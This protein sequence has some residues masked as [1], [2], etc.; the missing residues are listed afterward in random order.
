M[1]I[2]GDMYLMTRVIG[3]DLETRDPNLMEMGPGAVRKDGYVLGIALYYDGKNEYIPLRHDSGNADREQTIRFL[4]D[5]LG[6]ETP[7][8]GANILYDLEWLKG[9]LGITVNGPK[10]D[11]QIAE[12]LLDEEKFSYRLE[13]LCQQYLGKSKSEDKLKEAAKRLGLSE[14]EIKGNLWRMS[15]EDVSEYAMAD[16]K[17]A[18][19]IWNIQKDL[20]VKDELEFVFYEMEV[21]MVDVL[22]A[23]RFK[24]VPID[25]DKAVEIRDLLSQKESFVQDELNKLASQEVDVWSGN[26]IAQAAA[27]LGLP[28][29]YTTKGNPS[30]ESAWLEDRQEPFFKMVSAVRKFNRSGSVFIE[31]KILEMAY[32]GKVYP[33]F[34][35]SKTD[36]GGTKSGRFASAN[37]NMQQVPSRDKELAPLVRSLFIPEPGCKWG[38]FD[39][40][41]QEPRVTVNYAY[42]SHLPGAQDA[43]EAYIANPNIDYHQM[44]ADMANIPRAT[45]KTMNLG[46][47]YGMGKNKMADQLGVTFSEA[48]AIYEQYHARVPFIKALT[49]KASNLAEQRGYIR[50]IAGRRKRFELWGPKKYV[51]GVVPKHKAEAQC[52][53]EP[54]IV[55]YFTYRA[56]NSL[57]QGSSADMTK[58]AMIDMYRAG[59][60]PSLTVHDEVDDTTIT[61]DKQVKEITEIMINCLANHG[62]KMHIPLLVDVSVGKSWG[63]AE[64]V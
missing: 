47:A 64:K 41:Q 50:T 55:R 62:L 2:G 58:L 42:M 16:A 36:A 39:Y 8:V 17:D 38:K 26:V 11:V 10:Y 18:V 5:L 29:P 27:K 4:Q 28:V 30:F 15:V 63:E 9:D 45:A 44:V 32:N 57:I 34:R 1:K 43:Y 61:S 21:P 6:D 24:G 3:V 25:M 37:P 56:M 23:M 22:L 48:S 31:K 52:I 33:T 14:K 51:K 20:L 12:W 46:L 54:P 19:D 60:V 35:Q 49:N 13:V 7:K 40:K 53:Y 59:Y